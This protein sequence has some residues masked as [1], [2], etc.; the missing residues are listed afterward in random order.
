MK[1]TI[2]ILVILSVFV[3]LAAPGSQAATVPFN[4]AL[5]YSYNPNPA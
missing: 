5:T 1:T 2:K 3:G 4:E